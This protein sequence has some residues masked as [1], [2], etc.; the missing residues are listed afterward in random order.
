LRRAPVQGRSIWQDW[1][2]YHV[3][4]GCVCDDRRR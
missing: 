4:F 2:L 3:F 1:L